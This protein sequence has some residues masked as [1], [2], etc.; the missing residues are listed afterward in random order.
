MKP[1]RRDLTHLEELIRAYIAHNPGRTQDDI[2]KHF[3]EY[4][5]ALLTYATRH[6][7]SDGWA[8]QNAANNALYIREE[9]RT[10]EESGLE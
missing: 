7:I 1:I 6:L 4:D 10:S 2:I 8:D 5:T 3:D 9:P